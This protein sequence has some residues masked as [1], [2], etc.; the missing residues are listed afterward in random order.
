[1]ASWNSSYQLHG[2]EFGSMSTQA[3]MMCSVSRGR[4]REKKRREKREERM[5]SGEWRMENEE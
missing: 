2:D 3:S 1:M 5:E 4:A